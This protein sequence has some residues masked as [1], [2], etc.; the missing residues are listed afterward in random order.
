MGFTACGGSGAT[1]PATQ[2]TSGTEIVIKNFGFSPA[3]LTV[4]TG[5]TVTVH[6][7]D[8]SAHTVTANSGAFDTGSIAPGKTVTFTAPRSGH[9]GYH[10]AFHNFMQGSLTV[11][12]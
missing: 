3:S 12:A 4:K 1:T 2:S 7:E 9:Y 5:T 11:S 8:A 6:N 10:C